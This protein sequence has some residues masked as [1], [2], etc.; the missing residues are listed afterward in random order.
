MCLC[1]KC[2]AIK[3]MALCII[4]FIYAQIQTRQLLKIA[5][6]LFIQHTKTLT[7][8]DPVQEYYHWDLQIH[9]KTYT[10]IPHAVIYVFIHPSAFF[11]GRCYLCFYC[12]SWIV[13]F[14]KCF[15]SNPRE[16]RNV[17][18]CVSVFIWPFS[19]SDLIRVCSVFREHLFVVS[20]YGEIKWFWHLWDFAFLASKVDQFF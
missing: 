19:F 3:K 12:Y 16:I 20:L 1:Q 9:Y 10:N 13:I 15:I 8:S 2:K 11:Y 7:P 4:M 5:K 18:C 6:S 17:W 14:W